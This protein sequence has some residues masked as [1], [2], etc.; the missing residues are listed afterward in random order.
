M[1]RQH[2]IGGFR[3]ANNIQRE[4]QQQL[5]VNCAGELSGKQVQSRR[6]GPCIGN[7]ENRRSSEQLGRHST[8]VDGLGGRQRYRERL[9]PARAATGRG[10]CK[11]LHK[12]SRQHVSGGAWQKTNVSARD[13]RIK[14]QTPAAIEADGQGRRNLTSC[15]RHAVDNLDARTKDD[16]LL[17]IVPKSTRKT[18]AWRFAII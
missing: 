12:A 8:H 5:Q 11:P 4:I 16:E 7:G 14:T 18:Q 1:H 2:G 13:E 6:H 15:K 9:S 3:G 10:G 17:L